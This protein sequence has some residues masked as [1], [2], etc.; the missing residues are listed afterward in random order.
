MKDVLFELIKSLEEKKKAD[1]TYPYHVMRQEVYAAV[2]DALND[3]YKE[4]RISV[5]VSLNDKWVTTNG[6]V[7]AK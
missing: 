4:G 6:E 3:L 7:K 5:G 1:K 2:A